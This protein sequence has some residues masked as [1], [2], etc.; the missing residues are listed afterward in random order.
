VTRRL[1]GMRR[2]D[3]VTMVLMVLVVA[4]LGVVSIALLGSVQSESN[5]ANAA[6]KRDAAFQA[7]EA[8]IHSYMSKLVD[9]S[10]FYNH[11]LAKGEATRR[12]SSGFTVTGSGTSNVAWTYGLGWTYPNGFDKWYSLGN[13]YEY[14]L[15][16]TPPN[17]G[18]SAIDIVAVGRPVGSTT[19]NRKIE[20]L[21]RPANLTDFQML[22]NAD[23]SYN[24]VATT[25]GKIYAGKDSAGVKH[26]VNHNGTAYADVYAEGDVTGSTTMISPA[27][28]YD[29]DT[30]P[31]IRSVI[32]NPVNFAAFMASLVDIQGASQSAGVY[33]N[34]S[35]AAAWWLEFKNDGTFT[36]KK[37]TQSGGNPVEMVQPVCGTATT[38]Y[39]PANGAIYVGQTAIVSNATT[40]GG[41]KGRVTVASNNNLVIG[42]NI[43][44]VTPG[45]DVL[46]LIGAVEM[47]VAKWTPYNLTWRAA[48]ISE[49]GMWRSA[50]PDPD[51][52][53]AG[54]Y[55]HGTMTFTGSTATF[56]GQYCNPGCQTSGGYMSMFNTARLYEYDETLLYLQPPWFPTLGDSLTM[57][58]FRELPA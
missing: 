21:V 28:K 47:I 27:T 45:T 49:H 44:P 2:E 51:K 35:T 13:G 6:V 3:G 14:S 19:N 17:P 9:D 56:G 29:K 46:G 38:Y 34:D 48:T 30:N 25:K 37:C 5:R 11:Y 32:A 4:L 31:T 26:N 52:D 53:A 10:V 58:M 15:K 57:L 40:N 20:T 7:A 50:V 33:L 24:A 43:G 8:G 36:A 39:V 41:V 16:I 1:D 12:S 55:L 23:I 18:S 22:S 42:N 54:N